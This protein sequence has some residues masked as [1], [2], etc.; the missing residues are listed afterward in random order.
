MDGE[1]PNLYFSE[2]DVILCVLP[3]FHI[4]SLS[5]IL[6]CGLRVGA[7][8]LIMK[9]F[10]LVAVMELV[11]KYKITVAPLV[12]PIVVNVAKNA[13]VEKYDLSSIRIVMSGAASMGKDIQDAFRSK[14]PNAF[15]GQVSTNS[16]FDIFL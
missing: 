12:P 15:L 13:L 11:Q 10:E 9:K 8:I 2:T 7:S 6:L 1:N 4:Y 16:I 5:S 3:M 14:I